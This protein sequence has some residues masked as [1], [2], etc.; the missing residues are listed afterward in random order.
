ML[1]ELNLIY[2]SES[3]RISKFNALASNPYQQYMH[4]S[5]FGHYRPYNQNFNEN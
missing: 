2:R 4:F 5:D 1:L 3:E